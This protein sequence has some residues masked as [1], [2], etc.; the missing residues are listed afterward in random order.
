[1]PV[2]RFTFLTGLVDTPKKKEDARVLASVDTVHSNMTMTFAS[3][4]H[5]AIASNVG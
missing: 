3:A 1:M 4:N 5:E 2:E